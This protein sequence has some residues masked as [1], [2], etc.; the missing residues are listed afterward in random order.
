LV[1]D[2]DLA[3]AVLIVGALTR[4]RSLAEVD[5]ATVVELLFLRLAEPRVSIPVLSVLV[6][7]RAER[8]LLSAIPHAALGCEA[9]LEHVDENYLITGL[10]DFFKLVDVLALDAS[11]LI[12]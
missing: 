10:E 7:L 5:V 3:E 2:G 6:R 1:G 12:L 8:N 11:K 4:P 9:V